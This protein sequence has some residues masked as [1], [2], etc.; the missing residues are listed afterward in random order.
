[1]RRTRSPPSCRRACC[2]PVAGGASGPRSSTSSPVR[3]SRLN[4]AA[5]V[6]K[7]IV[8]PASSTRTSIFGALI[9]AIAWNLHHL[10]LRHSVELVARAD[11]RHRSARPWRRRAPRRCSSPGIL[12]TA[13]VHLHLAAA[14]LRARRADHGRRVAG[15]FPA[16]RPRRVDRWF[17]R[18]QLVSAGAYSLGHG[19]NDAQKTMGIIWMLL[20]ANRRRRRRGSPADLGRDRRCYIAIALGTMF[21]GWRI[22][23]TMGQ[24]HHAS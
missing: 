18:L 24:K 12:K 15:C 5:T 20:I 23:K 19:G 11:R 7:G 14:R 6:G 22:V 8:D 1:M 10:V 4:V 2:E 21:G 9:G 16:R 17:R 13:C 3:S